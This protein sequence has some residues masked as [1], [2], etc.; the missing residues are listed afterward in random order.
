MIGLLASIGWAAAERIDLNL[1]DVETLDTLPGLGPAKAQALVA[2]RAAHGPC[3]RVADLLA[4]PGI[5]AATV[6][7]IR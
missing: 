6:A 7:A 2:W 3:S 1:A 4:V 5:G